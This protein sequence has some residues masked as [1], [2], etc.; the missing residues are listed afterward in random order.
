MADQEATLRI[1]N[2]CNKKLAIRCVNQSNGNYETVVMDHN[3]T[4]DVEVVKFN[5]KY[6]I[7]ILA[8]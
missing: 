5:G 7:N 4:E 8:G 6:M 1:I 2:R 3:T